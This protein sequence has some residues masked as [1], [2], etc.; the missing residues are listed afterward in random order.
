[1][2]W[3]RWPHWQGEGGEGR[4]PELARRG[5]AHWQGGGGE[6]SPPRRGDDLAGDGA[7]WLDAGCKLSMLN[8]IYGWRVKG[9]FHN[10]NRLDD[11]WKS[12]RGMSHRI[13]G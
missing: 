13:R 10:P 6:N 3:L 1:V 8:L 5:R 2:I 7:V 4:R 11:D 12:L 9:V